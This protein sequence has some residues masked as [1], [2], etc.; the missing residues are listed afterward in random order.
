MKPYIKKILAALCLCV[1]TAAVLWQLGMNSTAGLLLRVVNDADEEIRQAEAAQSQ[2]A[3]ASSGSPSASEAASSEAA[4]SD[5]TDADSSSAV[6]EP[7]ENSASSEEETASRETAASTGSETA[8]GTQTTETAGTS[9][10]SSSG[11]TASSSSSSKP[12]VAQN[13]ADAQVQINAL[14]AKLYKVE[15][16]F[17]RQLLEIIRQAHQ[18]YMSY[19][20]EQRNAL[21]KVTVVMGKVSDISA[22]EKECDA[23]VKE[24]TDQMTA[25]LKANNMDT[26]IVKEVQTTYKNKK[27]ALKK[28]LIDQTYSGG[29]GSGTSGHWL[30]DRLDS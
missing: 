3:A 30:Y 22:M 1:V 28:E 9:S 19:P 24:I 2:S 12:S 14:I 6:L 23:E 17:E 21:K 25:I 18:E 26:S 4:E 7:E 29:D 5:P 16:K 20:K 27:A 15:D 10:A 8:A 11:N 13:T